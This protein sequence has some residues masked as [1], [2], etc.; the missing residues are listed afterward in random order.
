MKGIVRHNG[1]QAATYFG[2]EDQVFYGKILEISD[3]V[4]FEGNSVAEVN[5]AFIVAIKDYK[6]TC[7]ELNKIPSPNI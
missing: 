2:E 6:V 7:K 1:Y 5:N 3:L 4:T